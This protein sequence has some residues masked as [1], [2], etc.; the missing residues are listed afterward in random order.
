MNCLG[1]G[2]GGTTPNAQGLTSSIVNASDDVV[3]WYDMYAGMFNLSFS[4]E[5]WVW[6]WQAY[7]AQMS[8]GAF[9][10]GQLAFPGFIVFNPEPQCFTDFE[11]FALNGQPIYSAKAGFPDS[12]RVFLGHQQQCFRF[13]ISLGCNSN[14]GGYFDNVSFAFVDEPGVPGQASAG[15]AVNLGSSSADIWQF[16]NDTFPANETAGLPGTPAFDTTT[17]LIRTGLNNAQATGNTL[18]F[19]IPGCSTAVSAANATVGTADDPTLVQVR[20]DMVFRILPG[21]GNYQIAAGRTMAP[22]GNAVAGVL[23]QVPTNQAAAA[24][25]GDASFWGQYIADPGLVGRGTHTGPGGWD[26]LTWNSCRMDTLQ[27]NIFPVGG[28]VPTG[29]GLTGGRYMTTIHEGDPKFATLGVNKF[30][31]FVI[32]TTKA[33]TSSPTLNNVACDGSIPAWLSTV[34]QSRTGFD[35]SATTKEFSPIIPDGQ[36]TPGAHVQYFYR[37]S[38]AADPN[39]NFSVMPDTARITPQAGEGSTDQHR[40][41]QFGVLPDRWKNAAFGGAGAACMLYIDLNDRRGNEGRFVGAMDSVAATAAV[42]RGAHNGWS[43]PGDVDIT[44]AGGW[45]ANTSP[46]VVANRNSQPGTTWDMYGVKASESLT[47]SAGAP[48]SRL[49]N[50]S[51]MGFAAGK[52]SKAGP[53]PEMLRAYYRIVAVLSGDLNSGVL[54]PFVN[55]SQNDIALFND[56]LTAA[57]GLPQPRGIFVQGDGFGQSEKATGGI[58]PNHILFMTD[59]LGVV[60]RSPS[61]QSLAGNLNDCADILTTVALT[62]SADVYGVSNV[63]TF[64]NDVYNRNPAIAEAVEGTFYENVGLNGPYVAD[65]VKT[66]VPLRNW[67]AVTS[68][69]EIEHIYGRYCDTDNGRLAYYYYMLNKVFQSICQ[70]TGAPGFTLDTPQGNRAY[71]NFM[72]IGNSVMRQGT[73]VVRFSVAKAGR[74]QVSIYDVTGRKVRNLADRVF[75]AGEHELKWDGTADGGSKVARGV[76]FV[77]SSVQKDAGRIIVLNN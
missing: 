22:G 75:T 41:Q 49:A 9:C 3:L 17:G 69:F 45:H 32:D 1:N 30:K 14:E 58:D 71:T 67:V 53:T 15:S 73:S 8:N 25:S 56:Y 64:S 36:L 5:S 11:P 19:D 51:G 57:A 61:Y 42:K 47:T 62:N 66:A 40:W 7:P 39:L 44:T 59:K 35:G 6:G 55:R 4:G 70:I 18:R 31:C 60:F 74:V 12:L 72:K 37:K 27:L 46:G 63:C 28:A 52:E 26:P 20:L 16:F 68:G 24:V 2:V 38:H 34:P 76:Y 77:R 54:G 21:P 10:W 48:G 65:V 29:T 13:A 23:L 43:A 50:R 33:A